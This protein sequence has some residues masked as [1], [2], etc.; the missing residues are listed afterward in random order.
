[1]ACSFDCSQ[2]QA[3]VISIGISCLMGIIVGVLLVFL[4]QIGNFVI[5]ASLGVIIAVYT[6]VILDTIVRFHSD[7]VLYVSIAVCALE[8]GCFALVWDQ[9]AVVR[10]AHR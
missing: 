1:M 6:V 4:Y 5:G 8:F 7:V 9:Y 10:A 3:F 2:S